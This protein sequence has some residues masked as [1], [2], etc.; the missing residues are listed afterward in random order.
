MFP[1][2]LPDQIQI[3][4]S[5]ITASSSKAC[6]SCRLNAHSWSWPSALLRN[7]YPRSFSLKP[8]YLILMHTLSFKFFKPT[9]LPSML[10]LQFLYIEYLLTVTTDRYYRFFLAHVVGATSKT[11]AL[12]VLI[13]TDPCNI[14][15]CTSFFFVVT[16]TATSGYV[17]SPGDPYVSYPMF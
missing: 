9:M 2:H 11:L 14:S 10:S 4:L 15:I 7:Q 3:S 8:W 16:T 13:Y 17:R 5:Y 12:I 6:L 1:V